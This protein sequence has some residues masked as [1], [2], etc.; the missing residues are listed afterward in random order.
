MPL[1]GEFLPFLFGGLIEGAS[2]AFLAAN[3]FQAVQYYSIQWFDRA[4]AS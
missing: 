4:G 3:R 2:G 1:R